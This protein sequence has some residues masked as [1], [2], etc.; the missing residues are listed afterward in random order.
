M[1][2]SCWARISFGCAMIGAC[3]AA[4]AADAEAAA[5][6]DI[7]VTGYRIADAA[8]AAIEAR[9][10]A[11]NPVTI[12]DAAQL[13][14]F[15]DQPLGD[16]LRRV[17][18]VAFP[19]GNRARDIQLRGLGVEYTQV[20]LNG[21]ALLDGNSKRSVQVD[22]IPS[23]LVARIE[24]TRSP[25]AATDGQG[26][27]GTVNIIL[28]NQAAGPALEV[29]LG[30]G[31]LEG[32][33]WLGDT[34]LAWRQ[35]FGPLSVS[36]LGGLQRQGRNESKTTLSFTGAGAADAGVI[37]RNERQFDQ[38]NIMPAFALAIGADD[39]LRFAPSY[40]RTRED[41]DDIQT[42]LLT[43]QIDVRRREVE[44]RIRVRQN[45]TAFGAWDHRFGG[46]G[47]ATLSFD[48]QSA[49][50]DTVRDAIRT[51][52]AGIVD[53]TR[54]RTE[55]VTLE[56]VNPALALAFTAGAHSLRA[57]AD[58][59]RSTRDEA[60]TEQQDGVPR[61][62]NVSRTYFITEKR[63]NG[64]VQ[65][66][67]SVTEAVRLTLGARIE[68]SSTRTRDA[69]GT[70]N[71]IERTFLLPSAHLAAQLSD[72]LDLRLSVAR[73]L[74]RP[75]LRELSPTVI[76]AGGSIANPDIGG[77]PFLVPESVW[78]GD[79]ALEHYFADKRGLISA[80]L[81]YRDFSDKIEAVSA[82]EG[83]RTVQRPQNS[84]DGTAWGGQIDARAPLDGLGL[85]TVALWGNGTWT[86]TRLTLPSGQQR[87][88]V[89]QPDALLN[90]GIDAD[91]PTIKTTFGVSANWNSGYRQEIIAA[92]G[93]RVASDIAGAIRVDAS[94]RIELRESLFL[95][96][97]ALNLFAPVERRR[98]D[99][100][101]AAGALSRFSRTE[102]PTYRTFYAR[103]QASF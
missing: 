21:R 16:A 53:R 29:G 89:N 80:S 14:Q 67:W 68:Q 88:F 102:E 31:Y 83:T 61:P 35:G 46:N 38:I 13:N 2:I 5:A 78:G 44:K 22:R 50:E 55:D 82:V 9:R 70:E 40:L 28:K 62:P 6:N 20:L 69:F 54:R 32:N 100:I 58:Y 77:N 101:S 45:Y 10:A 90:L 49:D 56:R 76:L 17:A 64:F 103:L 81:F 75:D 12:I 41:R 27:S 79:A 84:G 65:D 87:R 85:P 47:L 18:G 1:R 72:G 63:A 71:T 60:N 34:T 24:I 66:V 52:A 30:S 7:I 26:A 39:T 8:V 57:G 37:E 51:N 74:R 15:G 33:G 91:V 4:S 43:N 48:Y 19:S 59:S 42:D 98:D 92:N 25:I 3:G 94:A 93:T 73:T 96:L 36:V 23:S 86:R 97:S 11:P 99:N 95:S